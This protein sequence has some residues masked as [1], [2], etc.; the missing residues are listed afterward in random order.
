M[1][2]AEDSEQNTDAEDEAYRFIKRPLFRVT[3]QSIALA[4][5]LQPDKPEPVRILAKVTRQLALA[6]HLQCAIDQ[7]AIAD[8]ARRGAQAEAHARP[9][10]AALR[11][12][13]AGTRLQDA[14]V[15]VEPIH[16]AES[17]SERTLRAMA[18][19]ATWA[20]QRALF[21]ALLAPKARPRTQ[22]LTATS[23]KT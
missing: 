11:P 20:E 22:R 9:R 6:H 5:T 17:V 12:A 21:D 7:G 10:H 13:R 14:V 4:E 1:N 19:A 8:R 3:R 23:I 2:D 16:G 18:H 15:H